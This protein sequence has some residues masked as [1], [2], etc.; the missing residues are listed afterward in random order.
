MPSMAGHDAQHAAFRCPAGMFFIPSLEGISH[1][2]D[3]NSRPEDIEMAAEV[4]TAWARA[5][6][7]RLA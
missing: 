7:A 1:A 3:E 2:P 5:V 4:M 6:L